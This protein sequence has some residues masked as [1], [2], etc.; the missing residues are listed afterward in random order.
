LNRSRKKIYQAQ[1]LMLAQ[2][3]IL[4][5]ARRVAAAANRPPRVIASGSCAHGDAD[6]GSDMDLFVILRDVTDK[7]AE[8]LKLRRAVGSI[9]VGVHTIGACS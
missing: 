6:A 5:A 8:Y 4:D 2:Q 3:S 9:G 1:I 7:A